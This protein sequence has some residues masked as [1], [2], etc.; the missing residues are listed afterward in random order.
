VARGGTCP[1]PGGDGAVMV[2]R[3]CGAWRC[4][5]PARRSEPSVCLTT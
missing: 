3:A 1:P 2:L 5:M 4:V